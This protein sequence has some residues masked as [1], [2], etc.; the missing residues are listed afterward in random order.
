MLTELPHRRLNPLTGEWVLVSPQRTARP[1][2]GHVEAT[3]ADVP[4]AYDPRCYLC[5]GNARAAGRRNPNYTATF[6]FDNDYPALLPPGSAPRLAPDP[7]PLF[8]AEA[9]PGLCR[10]VCYSPRHDLTLPELALEQV[11]AV[12]ETW[13]NQTLEL[14]AL[15]FI[16]HVQIFEN[17][18]EAMGCSNPHPHS[19][20]WASRHVPNEPAKE[21]AA[22]QAYL[23]RTGGCLVCDLTREEAAR[24]TRVVAANASFLVI[25]PFWAV[26]PFETL[27]LARRHTAGLPDLEPQE[28]QDLAEILRAVTILYDNLFE[29]SFPYSM[30]FHQAAWRE[31]HVDAHH[32]H[33]HFYPPLLRSA[34]VRKFMVGYEMLAMPQRDLTPETAA[35]ALR[36]LPATHYRARSAASSEAR[37]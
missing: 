15:D 5:P 9:E 32:L 17:K 26:W 31:P 8:A 19:Q 12:V 13:R 27:L 7:G 14:A 10:V 24:G 2:Q 35:D 28:A 6:V 22:Q 18:G 11:H 20:V 37:S 34:S 1:W 21:A 36:R 33:V 3:P 25:V 4:P 30:G 23:E 16:H 29:V